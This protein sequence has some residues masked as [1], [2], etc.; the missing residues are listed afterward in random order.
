MTEFIANITSFPVAVL[1]LLLMVVVIYW[2]FAIIGVLG[3]DILDGDAEID[4]AVDA[5]MDLDIDLDADVDG[6]G[7]GASGVAGFML[8]W[9]LT[10][11]PVTV[12]FSVLILVAWIICYYLVMLLGLLVSWLPLAWLSWIL[13]AAALVLS[14]MIAVPITATLI[15]PLKGLFKTHDA[16]TKSD[17]VGRIAVVKT[18]S[19]TPE[20]GQAILDD[21]EAG[22]LLDIRAEESEA[23]KKDDEVILVEYVA[24][25]GSY[26]VMKKQS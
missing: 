21:G 1:T 23:L 17:L 15:K 9:G 3:V 12:V 8:K 18:S 6:A 20:F 11:V 4:L 5:D 14:V 13:G 2:L 24:A 26:H 10:G 25:D 19:V 22:M 7:Q 16:V